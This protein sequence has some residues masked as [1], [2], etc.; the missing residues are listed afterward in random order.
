MDGRSLRSSQQSLTFNNQAFNED[1]YSD[2]FD[3]SLDIEKNENI[4]HKEKKETGVLESNSEVFSDGEGK[5]EKQQKLQRPKKPKRKI[6]PSLKL[7]LPRT[8]DTTPRN[9]TF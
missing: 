2:V 7:T 4:E 5:S 3:P 1:T 9:T 6:S 8:K